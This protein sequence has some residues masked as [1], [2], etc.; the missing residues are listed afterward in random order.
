MQLFCT[1]ARIFIDYGADL[2]TIG[3]DDTSL[4]DDLGKY[5]WF[6]TAVLNM[7]GLDAKKMIADNEMRR[8]G[9]YGR[10]NYT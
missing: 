2:T 8:R 4:I 3:D 6:G 10:D 7:M 5:K 9:T 1:I